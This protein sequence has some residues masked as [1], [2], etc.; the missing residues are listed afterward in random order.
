M[1]D[2]G[3]RAIFV[4]PGT[5]DL[6]GT[7]VTSFL[8]VSYDWW[9]PKHNEHHANPNQEDEDP[10]FAIPFLSFTK[11]RFRQQ[12]GFAKLLSKYQ[13][14]L[15]FPIGTLVVFTIR[16]NSLEYLVK[17]RLFLSIVFLLVG[18]FAWFLLPFFL[19]PLSKAI[20]FLIVQNVITGLYLFNI[21]APNH[22]GMPYIAKGVKISFFEH[23]VMTARNIYG[24]WLTDFIYMG[25]NYQIEHHLFPNCPRNKLHKITPYLLEICRKVKLE[26]TQVS[27]LESNKII[28]RELKQIAATAKS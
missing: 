19:F 8:G 5:N 21:F 28:L 20:V 27:V 23:Q 6:F 17:Q 1:H 2:A 13:M 9:R 22:K 14:Y 26:Y 15:Y 3:H 12:K 11:E 16:K 4:S 25:L 10:D 18:V 24:H 7:L